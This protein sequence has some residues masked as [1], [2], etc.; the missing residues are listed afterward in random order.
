[1]FYWSQSRTEGRPLHDSDVVLQEK[2]PDGTGSVGA[3]IAKIGHNVK[4]KD[5]ID[6]PQRRDAITS[7]GRAL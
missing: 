4:S 5:L 6:I 1:M 3:G 2:V 7:T